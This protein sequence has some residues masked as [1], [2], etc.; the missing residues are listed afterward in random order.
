M[1]LVS[2][3]MNC[4]NCSRYLAEALD[5]VYQQTFKDYEIILWD[6]MSADNSG[7]IARSYGGPLRYFRGE[8]FLPRE[9]P[10]TLLLRKQRAN[11]L[12]SLTAMTFGSRKSW[13]SRLNFWTQI[14]N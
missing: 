13:R 4:H 1:P 2:I 9:P 7:E 12:P 5:S 14:K 8:E 11:I 6:N 10:A 3:I